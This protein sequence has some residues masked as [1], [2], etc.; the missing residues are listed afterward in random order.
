MGSSPRLKQAAWRSSSKTTRIGVWRWMNSTP[1]VPS[2]AARRTTARRATLP[3]RR[4][5]RAS[6][7]VNPGFSSFV[8]FRLST[9]VAALSVITVLLLQLLPAGGLTRAGGHGPS[10]R[11]FTAQFRN[12]RPHP[13]VDEGSGSCTRGRRT[14]SRRASRR[15]PSLGSL[16]R[17]NPAAGH[18]LGP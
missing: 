13:G 10:R 4:K 1:R 8:S 18:P 6:M 17:A 2:S 14:S 11:R 15:S 7:R 16:R 5:S 3:S 12:G 9:A